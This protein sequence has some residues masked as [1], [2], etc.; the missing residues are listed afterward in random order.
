MVYTREI[1][2]AHSAIGAKK[3][4]SDSGIQAQSRHWWDANPMAYDWHDANPAPEGTLE[5]YQEIDR[6]F[7]SSSSFYGGWRPFEKLIPFD[8][9]GGRSV[10]EIGCGMG[11]HAELLAKSGCRLT[12]IDLTDRAVANTARRLA[13]HGLPSAVRQM[14]AEQMTFADSEFD[15]VWSWGVIHHSSNTD[16]ALE[17]I[18]RVLKP[19]GELRFMVYHRRSVSGFYSLVRGLASGKFFR[20]MSAADVLSGYTD[21]YLARFYTSH[22]LRELL[23]RCGFSRIETRILGQKSELLP[24]PG[25]GAIGNFKRDLLRIFPDPLAELVLSRFGYFLFSTAYKDAPAR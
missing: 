13:L 1:P 20:G 9:L 25:N 6:R 11:S 14:D 16:R 7:F 3:S 15:F 23:L 5:F 2:T 19:G 17:Q 8:R 10:L 22:E 18:Y 24:L 21:G 4:E 12:C